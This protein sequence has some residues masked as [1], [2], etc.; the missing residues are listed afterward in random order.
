MW[1]ALFAAVI[2]FSLALCL[3]AIVMQSQQETAE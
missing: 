1:V 3:A 2:A